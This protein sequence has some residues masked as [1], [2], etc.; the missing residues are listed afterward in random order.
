M[1][2]AKKVMASCGHLGMKGRPMYSP[3]A[4]ALG[5]SLTKH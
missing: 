1:V 2:R 4:Q 3:V 5:F